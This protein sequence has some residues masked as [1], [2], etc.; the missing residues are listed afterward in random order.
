MI[1]S[2]NIQRYIISSKL[3]TPVLFFQLFMFNMLIAHFFVPKRGGGREET[4]HSA[5]GKGEE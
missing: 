5:Q 3:F 2:H 4:G 1:P